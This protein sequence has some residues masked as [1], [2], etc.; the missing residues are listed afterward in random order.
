M[1]EHSAILHV[2]S[3]RDISPTL[4]QPCHLCGKVEGDYLF[5]HPVNQKWFHKPCFEEFTC[6]RR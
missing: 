1:T 2:P 5:Y 6:N 4:Q 3:I